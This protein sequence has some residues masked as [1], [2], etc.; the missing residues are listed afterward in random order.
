[1][2]C[3]ILLIAIQTRVHEAISLKGDGKSGTIL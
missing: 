2:S 3:N 1:M